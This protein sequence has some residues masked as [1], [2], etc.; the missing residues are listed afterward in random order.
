MTTYYN[1]LLKLCDFEEEEI[2]REKSRIEVA[3]QRLELGAGDME[4]AIKWM[5]QNHDMELV[6]VRRLLGLWLRELVDLVLAKDEGKRLVYYGF[7]TITGPAMAIAAASEDIHVTCPDVV[8]CYSMGQIFNKLTPILEAGEENGLPPGHGLCSLQQIRVGGLAKG[9]IPVPDLVLTSSYYCDMGS[10]T[11]ELLHEMYGHSAVYVDGSMDSRWGEFPHYLPERVEFL[12]GQLDKV[13]PKIKE[14]LGVE[15]TN[16]ILSESA[17]RKSEVFKDLSELV[18]LMKAADPQ[19][20]SIVDVEM[21][22][23]LTNGSASRRIMDEAPKAFAILNQEI[24]Q[25]IASG[26]GVVKKGSPRVMISVAHF[27]DPSIMRMME[28]IGLCIPVTLFGLLVSKGREK[29]PFISGEVLAN[30]EMLG[31]MFH[32]SYGFIKSVAEVAQEANIDGIIW[33]YLFNCRPLSQPSH[34]LKQ[35]VERETGIPV[36][37]LETDIYDSRTYS[38]EALRTRVETFAEIL[39]VR[40]ESVN[41]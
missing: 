21:A 11:D 8:L 15:V 4:P 1:A 28:N 36:L 38:A 12:G 7:P 35:F 13:F 22:R 2:K 32:S 26:I 34:L 24:K 6:G 16:E 27:S 17:A 19:P 40:K 10:K 25:R 9:I 3:F 31:G 39:Q 5:R 29:T 20:I 23:R 14:I 33:N 30:Q 41:V 37:S 18:E